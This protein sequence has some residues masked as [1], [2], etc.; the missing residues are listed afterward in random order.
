MLLKLFRDLRNMAFKVF[1]E[2]SFQCRQKC[3]L[4]EA[5]PRL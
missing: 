2:K 5:I 4:L 1:N 3:Q